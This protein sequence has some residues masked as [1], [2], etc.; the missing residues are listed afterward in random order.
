MI[1]NI[2]G[3]FVSR[4]NG[5]V[6]AVA[7]ELIGGF[8]RDWLRGIVV[9]MAG[10]FLAMLRERDTGALLDCAAAAALW[11][12]SFRGDI[13]TQADAAAWA[14]Q[15][16]RGGR[17][18]FRIVELSRADRHMKHFFHDAGRRG[19]WGETQRLPRSAGISSPI[20]MTRDPRI[21]RAIATKTGR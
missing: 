9:S 6:G 2:S 16:S 10:G 21:I 1:R 4:R 18:R 7:G 17:C 14:S 19:R 3:P 5:L 12:E 20:L 13:H 11:E 15:G 8:V